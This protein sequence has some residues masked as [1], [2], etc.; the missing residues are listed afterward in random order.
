MVAPNRVPRRLFAALEARLADLDRLPRSLWLGGLTHSRGGIEPRLALLVH[1]RTAMVAGELP[2]ADD[3]RWPDAELAQP[4]HGVFTRQ[5]LHTYCRDQAGL[6]DTVLQSLLFHLDFIVD[7]QD[8]GAEAARARQMALEAFEAD[9]CERRGQMD[10]LIEVFGSLP[11]D[12]KNTRW[13]Q[14]RGLLRSAGWQEVVRIRR[15]IERL[16]AL[17]ALIRSLGRARPTQDVDTG[18]LR[19]TPTL[20]PATALRATTRTVRVPDLPGETRGVERSD[21]IA[22]MLPIEST[23]L[24]HRTLRLVWHARRAERTLLTYEDDDRM[25]EVVHE[26]APVWLP[27]PAPQPEQRQEMGPMLICVD[28]SGSMQGGA[29]A[30]AKATVLEAVRHAHAQKRDC[31]VF[32]FGGPDEVVEMALTVDSDGIERIARFLGQAFRGGTDICGPLERCVDMLESAQWELADLLVATDG[33]FG[34]TAELSA[35]L[36]AAKQARGLR[37]QGV[38]IGDRET[39]GLLEIA[40]DVF[41]VP[42]WRRYGHSDA[43]SPVHSKSL[44][45]MY[46]P[47]ALRTPENRDATRSGGDASAAV[48]AGQRQN[49]P[50][51]ETR[52]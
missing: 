4:L 1:L 42:D 38:L 16:P 34:A 14:M 50:T 30:V 2:A 18:R 22:R 11:D 29:E 37:V 28:T 36:D 40:D 51:K 25:Q 48:R 7:Y 24:G 33:E 23:L 32:A 47:G 49:I 13:D 21:R 10:E 35:R 44:T 26:E 17:S 3:W 5:G 8:R 15:L 19:R 9:W 27:D 52:K 39:I 46:F 6:A 12:G 45:A 31:H 43:D 20:M 41:W